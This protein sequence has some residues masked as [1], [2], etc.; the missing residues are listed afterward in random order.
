MQPRTI[1]NHAQAW[2]LKTRFFMFKTPKAKAFPGSR[3]EATERHD[4]SR[5]THWDLKSI[6]AEGVFNGGSSSV[7]RPVQPFF[8]LIFEMLVA[9]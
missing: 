8:D 9:G 2:V 5:K 1:G 6:R 7:D 3:S 4:Y